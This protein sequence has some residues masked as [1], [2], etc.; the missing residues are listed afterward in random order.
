MEWFQDVYNKEKT[1]SSEKPKRKMKTPA[2][3]EA[4]E[5]FYNEHKYP[6]ESMKSQ[7]A[8]LIGLSEKQVSGWFCHRRLKD[9]K[10]MEGEVYANGKH[11][12]GLVHDHASGLRQESCSS[13][14]QGDRHF[15]LKEVESKRSFGRSSSSAVPAFEQRGRQINVGCYASADDR[16]S[17][18]SSA[19]QERLQHLGGDPCA[20]ASSRHSSRDGNYMLMNT[21]GVMSSGSVMDF[22]Y[23]YL[24]VENV[25]PTI[26]YV[27]QKLGR[28]YREDGPAL[29]I[30]F[31][32]LPPGAFDSPIQDANFGN[33]WNH[34]EPYYVGDSMHHCASSIPWIPKETKGYDKYRNEKLSNGS[35]PEAIGFR[36][37]M[38]RFLDQ[39]GLPGYQL[40]SRAL[41]T[42]Q[43]DSVAKQ[44]CLVEK[45]ED[46]AGKASD[47]NSHSNGRCAKYGT[48]EDESSCGHRFDINGQKAYTNKAFPYNHYYYSSQVS[49]GEEFLE[50]KFSKSACKSNDFLD[51]EDVL[52]PR[53][54]VKKEKIYKEKIV[55]ECSIPVQPKMLMEM[56]RKVNGLQF[57]QQDYGTKSFE[58]FSRRKPVIRYNGDKA[59]SLSEDETG[60][61]TLSID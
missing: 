17:G 42:K 53:R 60:G 26:S 2:Q 59:T 49:Q 34:F 57:Q 21:R 15:D 30:N 33:S 7:F 28:H 54:P 13:T 27:K 32:T 22:R 10:I 52:M 45:V 29:R 8:K 44:T 24:E 48:K 38:Q 46:F 41:L 4:L 31:D 61:T 35:Y 1:L 19:S 18:S 37:S 11:H 25:H 56:G 20:L 23:S 14:K 58:K 40:N 47:Y 9:K 6:S 36:K 39:D 43:S 12:N 3:V 51:T 55:S 16:C 5:K 50:S